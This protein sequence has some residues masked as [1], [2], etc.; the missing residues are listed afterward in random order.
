MMMKQMADY[1]VALIFS[2]AVLFVSPA[3]SFSETCSKDETHFSLGNKYAK[4]QSYDKAIEMFSR[5]IEANRDLQPAAGCRETALT[6]LASAYYNRGNS[7]LFKSESEKAVTD[8]TEAIKLRANIPDYYFYR[9]LAYARSSAPAVGELNEQQLADLCM[10]TK[11]NPVFGLSAVLMLGRDPRTYRN[12]PEYTGEAAAVKRILDAGMDIN[13]ADVEGRTA[14]MYASSWGHAGVVKMLLS[15]GAD[16]GVTDR[17]G[18]TALYHAVSDGKDNIIKLLAPAAKSERD[19]FA[20]ALNYLNNNDL[21]NA[22]L[23]VYR[24]VRLNAD[25]P[26]TRVLQGNI[27]MAMKDYDS[28]ITA[29]QKALALAPNHKIALLRLS[30]CYSSKA[31]EITPENYSLLANKAAAHL[32][33]GETGLAAEMFGKA[34]DILTIEMEKEKS[35]GRYLSASWYALFVPRLGEAEKYA[36]QGIGMNGNAYSLRKN[37]GHAFLLQGKKNE[38]L[39][40]YRKYLEQDRTRSIAA[41][42]SELKEDV[43]LLRLRYPEKK[44]LFNWMEGQ[45]YLKK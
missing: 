27:F 21:A 29:Y 15:R 10:A 38:A 12:I 36:M 19:N 34:L 7:W 32:K 43:S 26:D 30:L 11:L 42:I 9:A 39:T 31:A 6:N 4:E 41:F 44:D 17:Q 25:N 37:L 23:Y 1:F 22:A 2:L 16:A 20:L 35:A 33:V 45:L 24:A 5:F 13:M 14:L 18:A 8:L 40:E 28:A 3:N